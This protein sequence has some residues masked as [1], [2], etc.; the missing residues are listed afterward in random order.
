MFDRIDENVLLLS[1][2]FIQQKEYWL[3]KLSGD[4]TETTFLIDD[5]W[6]RK[7]NRDP[8][9][10]KSPEKTEII[11]GD[12]LC[13]GLLK[14]CKQSDHSL[15]IVLLAVLKSLIHLYMGIEDVMVL[16]PLCK[17]NISQQILNTLLINRD[18][19]RGDL[20]F[21]D[22]LLRVR[23]SVLAAY[24]NQDYPYNKLVEHLTKK[25]G[26]QDDIFISNVLCLLK[27]IH[28]YENKND[29][30]VAE[31]L[32]F[33]LERESEKIS[34]YIHFDSHLYEADIVRQL[35]RHFIAFLEH[36][37]SHLDAGINEVPYMSK[38]EKQRLLYDFN[39][40]RVEFPSH[41]VLH[42][43]F[44]E[45]VERTPDNT[46]VVYMDRH[47][48]YRQL[49]DKA[50]RMARLLRAKG[51]GRESIVGIIFERSI[52]MITGIMAILK[53]GGAY[54]PIDAKMP[55][56]RVVSILKQCGASLLLVQEG[57]LKQLTFTGLQ[58]LKA[59]KVKLCINSPRPQIKD[60]D[61]IPY[62]DRSLVNYEKYHRYVGQFLVRDSMAMQATRGCPYNC[63]YCHKIWPKTHVFRSAE[64]IVK[65]MQ[66]YYNMGVRRFELVDDIFNLN[67]ENSRRFF[68][69][70]IENGLNVQLF[71]LLRGD[72]LT[73][74]YIDL[75]VEAGLTQLRLSLETA[76]PRL[77]KLIGKN[78]NIEK[79]RRNME[80]ILDKYPHIIFDLNIIH[81]FPSESE[82]E[83]RLTL[84]FVKSLKWLHFPYFNILRIYPNTDMEKLAIDNG[85]SREAIL[86]SEE[87][88]WHELPTTLPF[89][90]EFT[91]KCQ[92]EFVNEYFCSRERLL[93]VLPHQMRIM[94]EAQIL[95]K[96]NSYLIIDLK[97]FDE[98]LD[99]FGIT[100]G[101]L[102]ADFSS[103]GDDG[104]PGIDEKLRNHFHAEPAEPG[105]GALKVLLLDLSM[106]FSRE[107]AG[108]NDLY[109]PPLGLMYVMTY[110]KRQLGGK[111][112]GKIV[113]SKV[114]FDSY[115]ELKVLLEAF[116]PDVIGIRTLTNYKHFFHKTVGMIRLWDFKGP[117]ITGGP[118][119]T[120]DYKIVLQDGNVDLAV[121]GE[122]EF[123]FAEVIE[124]IIKNKGKLPG[125]EALKEIPGIAFASERQAQQNRFA[126][127]IIV[128]DELDDLL[129]EKSGEN[130]ELRSCPGDLAYLIYTSGSTG[131]PKGVM[132]EH[133]NA[134]N[135]VSWFA[136]SY[137]GTPGTNVLQMS[138]YTFDPSINQVFG[139]LLHGAKLVLLPP[140]LSMDIEGMRQYINRHRIHVLNTIPLVLAEL[141]KGEEKLESVRV[142]LSGGDSLSDSLKDRILKEGCA[143][144]NQYGP[145]ETTIDALV[146][147]CSAERV[148]L[149]KPIANVRC[150]IF[151][152]HKQPVPIGIP[153]ELYIGG[154]GVGRGYAGNENM[155]AQRFIENPYNR[156]ERLYRT[157]DRARWLPDG[158]VEFLGRIDHQVKIRGFRIE[159][160]EIENRLSNIPYI[161]DAVVMARETAGSAASTTT[162][163][164]ERYLCAY[165]V[166]AEG[167]RVFDA[168]DLRK[169]LSDY[170]PDYMIPP[171]I[172]RLEE[173]P[174]T[175]TGKVD[176]NRLPEPEMKV[177]EG[178]IPPTT[179]K[180][181]KLAAIW[182]EVLEIDRGA[183]GMNSNF[184]E[185]GG[186]S[187]KATILISRIH[188]AF[189]TKIPLA[190]LF[191]TPTMHELSGYIT[192]GEDDGFESIKPTEAGKYY[193][194]SS[195][196]KR[197]YSLQKMMPESTS[198][199]M[200]KGF[201][202]EG[203][204]TKEKLETALREL[205]LRHEILRTS[206]ELLAGEPVQKI[207]HRVDLNIEYYE[208]GKENREAAFTPASLQH[209][210]KDF[211]K[212]FDPGQTPLFRVGLMDI[213]GGE[214]IFIFDMHHIAADAISMGILTKEFM[215]LYDEKGLPPLKLQYRDYAQW[216]ER[217]KNSEKIKQQEAYWLRHFEGSTTRLNLPVD[218][219]EEHLS[220][221]GGAVKFILEEE[222]VNG[223]RQLARQK[224]ST[225][226]ML[227]LSI[228]YV[229]LAKITNQED[230]VVGTVTD[231]RTH[232]D[233]ESIVGMF[234]N[235][236]A[237]RNFPR[238]N[239][240][241]KEF[242]DEVQETTI[243]AFQN[244]DYQFEDLVKR[245]GASKEKRR[246]PLFDVVFSFIT[247]E[248]NALGE[249]PDAREF[250]LI[251]CTIETDISHFDLVFAFVEDKNN[252]IM[253]LEYSTALFK[254]STI[255]EFQKDFS[256]IVNQVLKKT[257]IKLKDITISH[258]LLMAKQNM[259]QS[260]YSSYEF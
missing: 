208:P 129:Q 236:L 109:E 10:Q 230:I 49:N 33:S 147:K 3:K 137:L 240:T 195:A 53:A 65:E 27:N 167:S 96:Y 60:F 37:L 82:E 194:A 175:S 2:K 245:L 185:L 186:H 55:E 116:R 235:T 84:D 59:S 150:Y 131:K 94:N 239:K 142:V 86:E 172:I 48:T 224:K 168:V 136:R 256:D 158:N 13:E 202:V 128:M 110:L 120:S 35:S 101:E 47:L 46:A 252:L 56:K 34:G 220:F 143:L 156:P 83:A 207:H 87:L 233:L 28:L 95:Q 133:R 63:A 255:E 70:I 19:V 165:V 29:E 232:P 251:P 160:G 4:I 78:L 134:V 228:Y 237:L 170:L 159:L 130:P 93:S 77:Q 115:G 15:Y 22:L 24:E 162:K 144:Y 184:F 254:P 222:E 114:D 90:R 14:L 173:I 40:T 149:G 135:V 211:I 203:S 253:L 183:V 26:K 188:K 8:G 191:R 1:T 210:F 71:L 250:R 246:N 21:K 244:Q 206:I 154:A 41:K 164:R 118:Y 196:Q 139:T 181:K 177:G 102:A 68:R 99:F 104:L 212:P 234:V 247:L 219:S 43:L 204:I 198:Y 103:A 192:A 39:D 166:S 216:Q 140:E 38:S 231:G 260:D 113:K 221:D 125:E 30:A 9:L 213:G 105:A 31:R 257:D 89:D 17:E 52:P 112:C 121:L 249:L 98:L 242:F 126:R 189:S 218:Y 201:L 12:K 187:L 199:N 45:Q 20:G 197:L 214:Q 241:F 11:F 80:Y 74:E 178:F 79:L 51:V 259:L 132:V 227:M 174:R 7:L 50:N 179:E 106:Y 127:D 193:A 152:K 215:A 76:S 57:I 66:I 180:D 248:G 190:E 108:L 67:R 229:F 122:G 85:I 64:N 100:R 25:A 117:I 69:L 209:I 163:S 5:N 23:E 58:E 123:T 225:L 81:G 62:P 182:A 217:Q 223:L 151:N 119:A 141:L 75:M 32:V 200:P 161:E 36:V 16:S 145:T 153:G 176:R 205:T 61:S 54:L 146:A 97:S 148:T 42:G 238:E 226:F 124:K 155:T 157:G 73:E 258:D 111:V 107:K 88:G 91:L 6:N 171:Y 72:I 18:Q 243:G 92:T 138:E 44:Q 169:K